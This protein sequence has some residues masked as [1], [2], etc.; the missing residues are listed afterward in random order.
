[1][2]LTGDAKLWWHTR[3]S[4]DANA[5]RDKVETWNVLKKELKDQFLPCNTSWLARESL[6]KLKHAGTVR[7]YVKEFNSLMLDVRDM[8]DENNLFN[9]LSGSQTWAQ[10]ELRCQ[11]VKDLP[12]AIVVADRRLLG[13]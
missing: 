4:D 6:R 5:N 12:S 11:G 1:M 7:D 2:Y 8:S 3:L 10:T 13:C 9:S